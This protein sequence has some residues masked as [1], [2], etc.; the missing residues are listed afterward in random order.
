MSSINLKKK[1]KRNP[2][3]AGR[4]PKPQTKFEF[5]LENLEDTER[6]LRNL[7]QDDG[8]KDIVFELLCQ[9]WKEISDSHTQETQT[10]YDVKDEETQ[11][12]KVFQLFSL[13]SNLENENQEVF[14]ESL[15]G[16][17]NPEILKAAVA[18]PNTSTV[19]LNELL[20][21]NKADFISECDPRLKAFFT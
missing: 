8:T 2:R 14:M 16:L 6:D 5:D 17:F 10:L 11:T 9:M 1:R 19:T 21:V 15:G 20:N 4:K 12:D 7:C 13:F 18:T 3:N